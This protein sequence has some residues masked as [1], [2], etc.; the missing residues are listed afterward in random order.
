MSEKKTIKVTTPEFR[1]SFP[2][3]F[4]A[5]SFNGGKEQYSIC[6]LFDKKTDLTPI[7]KAMQEVIDAKWPDKAKR[8]KLWNPLR[9]GDAEKPEREEYQNVIFANA[10]SLDKPGIVDAQRNMITS[11][12][13][14]YAGCYARATLVIY[15]FEKSGNKGV[16]FG[17]NNIQKLRD[18]E[19]F[20]GRNSAENDFDTVEVKMEAADGFDF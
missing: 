16:A 17:L 4:E 10:K 2:Q 15:S 6:M 20:S 9:D 1:V 8:G 12:E 14:F 5:K 19:P 7:K 18:G 11:G 3:V 13:E